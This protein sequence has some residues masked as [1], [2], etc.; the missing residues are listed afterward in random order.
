MRIIVLFGAIAL[1]V[2]SPVPQGF[3]GSANIHPGTPALFSLGNGQGAQ[4]AG[5]GIQ[6]GTNV[7]GLTELIT[8]ILQSIWGPQRPNVIQG[9]LP[10]GNWPQQG[11]IQSGVGQ[12]GWPIGGSQGSWPGSGG[13]GG[14]GGAQGGSGIG[15]IGG[16]QGNWP[17]SG[18]I[19]GIGG[20][21]GGWPNRPGVGGIGQAQG[22]NAQPSVLEG[23]QSGI[24]TNQV[25]VANSAPETKDSVSLASDVID[26]SKADKV[27]K[28]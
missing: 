23:I 10:G 8:G 11:G 14:I 2:A 1:A 6:T 16:S 22:W 3:I 26:E 27:E 7:N 18:G 5:Q 21:Q 17:G 25:P 20:V 9:G 24:S 13:I 12:G 28:N 15:G 4:G 19:G